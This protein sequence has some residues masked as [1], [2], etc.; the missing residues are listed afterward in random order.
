MKIILNQ[1]ILRTFM[2]M[3]VLNVL[4]L[5]TANADFGWGQVVGDGAGSGNGF[6]DADN[7]STLSM[8]VFGSSLYVGTNGGLSGCEVWRSSNGTTWNPVNTDGFDDAN[9]SGARSMAVFGSYLYVGTFNWL[10]S[11]EVWRSIDGDTWDQVVGDEDGDIGNGFGNARNRVASSMAV[12]GSYLYVGTWNPPDGCEVWRSSNGTTWNPVK[13][14]G[15]SDANNWYAS[16]MAVFGSYLYV[17]TQNDTGGC[18]V[19]R[20]NDGTTWNQ[21]NTDGFDGDAN[22][23]DALSMAVFGSY[24]YVGTQNDTGGC[25]V[26]RSSDGT[27]WNQVNNDG[28]DDANNITARSISIFGS[29]LYV[30]TGNDTA[31]CEV[32]RSS[33]GTTWNPV[34]TDGFGDSNNSGAYAMPVFG[35]YLYVGTGNDTA[36]CEVWRL[37]QDS[38]D[39]GI[40]D[41]EDKCPC[42][43][44]GINKGICVMDVGRVVMSYEEGEEL[45]TCDE[46][47]DCELTGGYCQKVQGDCNWNGI[48]DVCERYADFNDSGDVNLV[49]LLDLILCY[50]KTNFETYPSCEQYDTNDDNR[51]SAWD[52]L[53]LALEYGS[54]GF[55]NCGLGI[56]P[57]R[58]AKTGQ[59]LCYT[60]S[61]PPWDP[62]N[63]L[64]TGQDGEYQKGV[65]G[66]SPRFTDNGDGTVTDNLTGL[67]WTKD[68]QEI[69][70]TKTWSEAITAC[71]DLDH[72]THTDWRLPNARELWSL[73]DYGESFPALPLGHPFLSVISSPHWTSTTEA[74][75]S[76]GAFI[77]D[78]FDGH[79][80][81]WDKITNPSYAWCM[82]GE[83][84]GP[85]PVPKTGQ[86]I[87]YATGDDGELQMGAVWPSPRFTNNLDGTVTDNLTGL[88]WL[89]NAGCFGFRTWD[90]ALSDCN[91]LADPACGLSD[92]S[93]AGEWRLPNPRELLSLMDFGQ[94]SLP[95]GYPF[96]LVYSYYWSSTNDGLLPN[97][98][99]LAGMSDMSI[100]HSNKTLLNS[101]WPV[102]GGQ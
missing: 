16:S 49:D 32:W 85:A 100:S 99:W 22:N 53:I 94:G 69:S 40:S 92:N 31:G 96:F 44:N 11:C 37:P 15:F 90:E 19:W 80:F 81:S 50:G 29:Y 6:G 83:T 28:F 38:D 27:T 9:N 72:A 84:N 71:N 98:A 2:L 78:I 23:E 74:S 79:I 13:T 57:A 65:I 68:S 61:G 30:G 18:E 87:S 47:I 8:A 41:D 63:C 34:N 62:I 7:Y 45:I 12:F 21:V 3:I 95:S 59:N 43:P 51:V 88:I 25:E 33:N 91:A 86:T 56:A 48:G 35:S 42:H 36:G 101:V 55:G 14:G 20:S 77:A 17:G 102:R 4:S 5:P 46:D 67:M 54:D 10:D 60:S 97:Y 66:P 73:I 1:R 26:W 24:L 76:N 58:V 82:R 52:Y 64:D 93:D 89:Q 70:G 75:D 39:D